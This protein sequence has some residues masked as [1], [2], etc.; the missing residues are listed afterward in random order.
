MSPA[1]CTGTP[2]QIYTLLRRPQCCLLLLATLRSTRFLLVLLQTEREGGL[3]LAAE[4][5][6]CSTPPKSYSPSAKQR[7]QSAAATQAAP[8]EPLVQSSCFLF[9]TA[10]HDE[11]FDICR[12]P[13]ST[14]CRRT[15][16]CSGDSRPPCHTLI[17]P[18]NVTFANERP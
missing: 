15:T 7:P 4:R 17:W 12:R 1:R 2:T 10:S 3:S 6:S 18:Q 5:G 13:A 8:L 9:L 11:E 14:S 16:S